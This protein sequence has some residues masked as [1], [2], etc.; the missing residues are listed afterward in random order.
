MSAIVSVLKC[1]SYQLCAL[2]QKYDVLGHV[3][4]SDI[5]NRKCYTDE[6]KSR[7]HFN[8]SDNHWRKSQAVRWGNRS[9]NTWSISLWMIS[10]TVKIRYDKINFSTQIHIHTY[11]KHRQDATKYTSVVQLWTTGPRVVQPLP[12]ME[13]GP[14]KSKVNYRYWTSPFQSANVK[15]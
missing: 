11:S 3:A 15:N 9:K 12:Y 2:G 8:I 14:A 13:G 5:E 6:G 4:A 10:K 7:F 1:A